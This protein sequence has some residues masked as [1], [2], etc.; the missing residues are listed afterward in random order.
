MADAI[1]ISGGVG[2]VTS[3]DVTATKNQVL[4]GYRT[5]TTDSGDEIVE[6]TFPTTSDAD[7]MEEFWYYNDHGEDSYVTRIPE[8]AYM[9]YWNADGTQ[10]WNPWIRIKRTLIKSGI[11]YRPELTIDTIT[12]LGEQGH[13]PDRGESAGVSYYQLR[14]D[15]SGR[16]YVLF[17][18][19]WYHR[20]PWTDPQGHTHEAYLYVTYEQLK[21][22]FGIDGSKML[23]GYGIAGVQG[24]IV[25]RPNESMTTEIVNIGWTAPKKIGLRFPPGY[26]PRAGQYD[27]IVEVNYQDLANALGIR[28]DKMLNDINILG[29]Q[30]GIP[31]WVS[32]TKQVISAVNNEGFVWDDDTGANRGRGIVVKIANGHV[33]AGADWVF[34]PSPN[35]YPHNIV[36][37]VNINGAIGTRDFIDKVSEYMVATD[38]EISMQNRNQSI[39]LGNAYANSE[40]VFFGVEIVGEDVFD[41]FVRRDRGN[42]RYLIGRIPVSK[43][44]SNL[45]GTFIR[46]T[47]VQI[48]IAR[49]N[50]GNI[51]L[52]HHGPN[53]VLGATK[54]NI[55]I[56]AHS[57]ISF[58]F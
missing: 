44:D 21:N 36:K 24:N 29:I 39:S 31:Y 17:K 56:Y 4:R 3:D 15:G 5:I 57:S 37:D 52:V 54:L 11:N 58:R 51:S 43:N 8:A 1:L 2:G 25:P 22:L 38:V 45:L 28:A 18:N 30:G 48:E 42:G 12:T 50:A 40:T 6:G 49:D 41:G 14:E 55:Y 20:A 53:Q 27:P 10:S 34:L 46:N 33:I 47:P 32:Y 9:R 19:G 35:L 7:S 16:L 23:Q 13:I 26:Y